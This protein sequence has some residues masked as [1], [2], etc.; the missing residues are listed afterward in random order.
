M[1]KLIVGL[2][3]NGLIFSSSVFA[4]SPDCSVCG[5]QPGLFTP[6]LRG[7]FYVGLTGISAQPNET[8]LGQATD[9]W[10]YI[11]TNNPNQVVFRAQDTS[12]RPERKL[13]W[14]I[15]GG[16]DI[17]CTAYNLEASYFHLNSDRRAINDSSTGSPVS[18][19]GLFFTNFFFP[20]NAPTGESIISYISNAD[21]RYTIDQADIKLGR[22]FFDICGMFKVQTSI[23]ARYAYLEHSLSFNS[24]GTFLIVNS[25]N[26]ILNEFFDVNV[27]SEFQGIGPMANLDLR[28]GI[29]RGLGL[30]AHINSA[31]IVGHV[32]SRNSLTQT[33]TEASPT[34]GQLQTITNAYERPGIQN[35]VPN[36]DGKI[37]ADYTYCFCNKSSLNF[38]IGYQATK[39]WEC[40]TLIRGDSSS[41]VS[42][43]TQRITDE[44]TTSFSFHGPYASVTWHM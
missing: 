15:T 43:P 35:V 17:P 37:G 8:G 16:Y 20:F 42:D 21:L 28:Y 32:N 40:F 36:V 29:Y 19:A 4:F 6:K 33:T 11:D 38:E 41:T 44:V 9:S 24:S 30:I 13:A 14:Q 7:G 27:R 12:I 39:Y 3:S 22:Q 5:Y 25:P 10:Q 34:P 2:I 18:L 26:T 31:L 1:K 23:G